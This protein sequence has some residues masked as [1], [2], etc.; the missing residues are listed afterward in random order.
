MKGVAVQVCSAFCLEAALEGDEDVAPEPAPVEAV[1][2]RIEGMFRRVGGGIT[3]I[4]AGVKSDVKSKCLIVAGRN[5][6]DQERVAI[7]RGTQPC[8]GGG[9]VKPGGVAPLEG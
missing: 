8:Q 6:F 9:T 1:Q 4:L 3:G 2:I 7:G 5:V